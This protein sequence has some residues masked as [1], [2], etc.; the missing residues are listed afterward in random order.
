MNN[1]FKNFINK[2]SIKSFLTGKRTVCV[3][4]KDGR[5]IEYEVTNPWKYIS[6]VKKNI[7]VESAWIK[8]G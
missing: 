4:Y 6:K 3:K 7:G 1:F 2:N 8:E 5:I